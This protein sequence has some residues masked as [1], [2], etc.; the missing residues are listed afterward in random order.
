MNQMSTESA[1]PP[2][3]MSSGIARHTVSGVG[4][5]SQQSYHSLKYSTA[6]ERLP[7]LRCYP[8]RPHEG[9]TLSH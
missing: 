4:P 3:L 2:I 7:L 5:L 8:A 6:M 9:G 1:K